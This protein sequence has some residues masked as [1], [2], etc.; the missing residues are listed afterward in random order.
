MNILRQLPPFFLV[1]SVIVFPVAAEEMDHGTMDHSNLDHNQMEVQQHGTTMMHTSPSDED[2]MSHTMHKS[3]AS[4]AVI[5]EAPP[6]ASDHHADHDM[7]KMQH[8]MADHAQHGKP[9][10]K[11]MA[12]SE[13]LKKLKQLPPSGKSR[14]ANYDGSYYMH[15]TSLEQ[16]LEARCALA[17]RGLMMLDN[18]SWKKC[19]GKPTGWSK[20]I[21]SAQ[22]DDEHSQHMK[23]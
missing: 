19:G 14:E 20:G 12:S 11:T 4:K 9:G 2:D 6:G 17:S 3:P 1:C 18:E 16:T 10:T 7:E 23:H 21:T 15:N 22:S 8:D 5:K 13:S